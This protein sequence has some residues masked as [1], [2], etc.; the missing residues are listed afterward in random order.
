MLNLKKI[1]NSI[2]YEICRFHLR[3]NGYKIL[4]TGGDIIFL[5]DESK[6]LEI[7][8][9]SFVIGNLKPKT[10]KRGTNFV[11][12]ENKKFENIVFFIPGE[13]PTDLLKWVETK[14]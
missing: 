6:N 14:K 1:P 3:K 11:L 12:K 5:T 10:F 8:G 2:L 9:A 7:N 4:Y 13:M